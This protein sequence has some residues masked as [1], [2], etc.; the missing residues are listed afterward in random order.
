[1]LK[2]KLVLWGILVLISVMLPSKS[3]NATFKENTY[4]APTNNLHKEILSELFGVENPKIKKFTV[5]ATSY[6]PVRKQCDERPLE[7][8][9][10]SLVS[11]GMLGVSRDLFKKYDLHLGQKVVLKG[12]GS[13]TITD[14]MNSRFKNRV[15]IISFIPQWSKKFGKRKTILYYSES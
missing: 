6:N 4:Q 13:F 15:D 14:K 7:T 12:L 9:D 5:L 1:M 3:G 8:A 2:H 10:G 11:P